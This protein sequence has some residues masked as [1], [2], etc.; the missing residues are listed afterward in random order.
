[1]VIIAST[2]DIKCTC[3]YTEAILNRPCNSCT[4][5]RIE[6]VLE[7]ARAEIGNAGFAAAVGQTALAN[8]ALSEAIRQI[9][10]ARQTLTNQ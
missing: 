2:K 6:D 7:Q 3:H 1:M 4:A 8:E 5:E 10:V 9:E